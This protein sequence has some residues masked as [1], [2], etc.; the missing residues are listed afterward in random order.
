MANKFDLIPLCH[1]LYKL[2]I[3]FVMT[4]FAGC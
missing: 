2:T 1:F 3:T 4:H